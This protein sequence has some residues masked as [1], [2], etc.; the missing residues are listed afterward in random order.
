MPGRTVPVGRASQPSRRIRTCAQAPRSPFLISTKVARKR[1][2]EQLLIERLLLDEEWLDPDNVHVQFPTCLPKRILKGKK[3]LEIREIEKE[4]DQLVEHGCHRGVLYWCLARLGPREDWLRLGGKEVPP[5]EES[6]ETAPRRVSYKLATR[7]DM[8]TLANQAK[9]TAGLIHRFRKELLLSAEA[10][11]NDCPLPEGLMTDGPCDPLDA[12][13]LLK[14]SLIWVQQLAACWATPQETTLVKSKGILYLLAYAAMF[15][16]AGTRDPKNG[17]APK[18][19]DEARSR[20]QVL[21]RR[22][23]ESIAQ[24]AHLH[25]GMDLPPADLITK[26]RRFE[27]DHPDLYARLLGLLKHLDEVARAPASV[28]LT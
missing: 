13:F 22:T 16:A 7:E 27:G 21:Q 15:P 18:K 10:L 24:I 5:F 4:L 14:S 28:P 12:H 2:S 11:G 23:A 1:I 20:S 8:A 25:S 17:D 6:G 26:L 19:A 3:P 9:A